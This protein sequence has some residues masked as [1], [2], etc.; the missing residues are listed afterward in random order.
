M[1]QFT[2]PRKMTGQTLGAFGDRSPGHRRN[3]TVKISYTKPTQGVNF[4]K[5]NGAQIDYLARTEKT[6]DSAP[7][8]LRPNAETPLFSYNNGNFRPLS[9][10]EA[11]EA[12]KD[13]PYFHII[14]S[15]EDKNV[16]LKK[17]TQRFMNE[18]FQG[19]Q[20]L[21]EKAQTWFA[22]IHYNTDKPH[23]HILCSRNSSNA[24]KRFRGKLLNFPQSYIKNFKAK[25]D[26]TSIL[27]QMLGTKN[28]RDKRADAKVFIQQTEWTTLDREIYRNAQKRVD[29]TYSINSD[30]LLKLSNER[31]KLV[32]ARLSYL[33]TLNLGISKE[34]YSFQLQKDWAIRL[35]SYDRLNA[36][37]LKYEDVTIDN[38]RKKPY[39]A[40][41]LNYFV[42]DEILNKLS[43]AVQ[44]EKGEVHI[45]SQKI[46]PENLDSIIGQKVDVVVK[47]VSNKEFMQIVIPTKEVDNEI[48][49]KEE[50]KEAQEIT[51]DTGTPPKNEKNKL[52]R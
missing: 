42:E 10:L 22:S 5:K 27:T 14:L 1:R 24:V 2:N 41:I 12:L 47:K 39:S 9:R 32:L 46:D 25:E 35:R 16:N 38:E 6:V 23:V 17:L 48:D 8:E 11:R 45:I 21:G 29:G 43:L 26:A 33:S 36:M 7:E 49:N 50:Q 52:E 34:P 13:A 3:I 40:K 19:P 4:F 37:G 20:G 51:I 31:T 18:S 28:E 15:P 44:D 30:N